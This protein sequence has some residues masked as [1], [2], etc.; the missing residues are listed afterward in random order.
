MLHV[1]SLSGEPAELHV[2]ELKAGLQET[3]ELL[4]VALKRLLGAQLGC[5]RLQLKL[6]GEDSQVIDNDAPLTGPADFTLVR[7]YFQSLDPATVVAESK[8]CKSILTSV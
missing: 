7:I 6:L 5:L 2:E 8:D 3:E 4:V 1:R